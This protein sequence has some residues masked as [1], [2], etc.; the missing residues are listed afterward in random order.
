MSNEIS[1]WLLYKNQIIYVVLTTLFTGILAPIT[2]KKYDEWKKEFERGQKEEEKQKEERSENL[3]AIERGINNL[4]KMVTKDDYEHVYIN[5]YLSDSSINLLSD[6]L[7]EK[8]RELKNNFNDLLDW[9]EV[10]IYI[11][12]NEIEKSFKNIT[13]TFYINSE[14]HITNFSMKFHKYYLNGLKVSKQLF[15]ETEL[16]F[17]KNSFKKALEISEEINKEQSLINGLNNVF[18]RNKQLIKYRDKKKAFIKMGEDII[19]EISKIQNPNTT[20]AKR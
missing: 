4:T 11:I 15:E 10:S 16:N 3:K 14:H 17:Y 6:N 13:P 8:L 2:L 7:I 19:L 18:I 1:W 9:C 5:D 12:Y 20:R